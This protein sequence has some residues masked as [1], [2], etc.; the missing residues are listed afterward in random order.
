MSNQPG[1]PM[2]SRRFEFP[3]ERGKILEFARA[4]HCD[5]PSFFG[6]DAIAPP[7]F[8]M[9]GGQIWGYSWESPGD[10]PLVREP[11]DATPMLHLEEAYRF[12]GAP[13]RAGELLHGQLRLLPP[14]EKVAAAPAR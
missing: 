5:N 11:T 6:R 3:V 4:I 8:L 12:D 9:V 2:L 1:E 10:S 14:V 7:T 13:L